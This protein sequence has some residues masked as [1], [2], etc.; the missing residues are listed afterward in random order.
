[1]QAAN[2]KL[3]V[4]Q[5][6]ELVGWADDRIRASGDGR[7]KRLESSSSY[8]YAA[9]VYGACSVPGRRIMKASLGYGGAGRDVSG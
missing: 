3:S 1:M 5:C 2:G 4:W 9:G 6:G 8:S 7:R